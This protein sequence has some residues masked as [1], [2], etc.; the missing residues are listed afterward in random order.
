MKYINLAKKFAK[1]KYE[2]LAVASM[3][4]AVSL[5]AN[6]AGID[7]IGTAAA[8]EIAKFAVMITAIGTAVLSVVVL[9]QGFKMAFNMTKTAR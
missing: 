6:A 5:S 4:G 1:Q 2:Q 9:I 7:E 3:L 8:T